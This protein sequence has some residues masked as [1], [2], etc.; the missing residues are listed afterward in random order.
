MP[1]SSMPM[2]RSPKMRARPILL[3]L[4]RNS[5][6]AAS[7]P[8]PQRVAQRVRFS[9]SGGRP[10][11]AGHGIE[12]CLVAKVCLAARHHRLHRLFQKAGHLAARNRGH[13]L[14]LPGDRHHRRRQQRAEART[15]DFR[16]RGRALH[17][18]R[19]EIVREIALDPVKLAECLDQRDAEVAVANLAIK[20]GQTLMLGLEHG[21][22][23]GDCV[24]QGLD[25]EVHVT[26][27]R[28]RMPPARSNR[29]PVRHRAAAPSAMRRPFPWRS[30]IGQPGDGRS[31]V[32]HRQFC[33]RHDC[34]E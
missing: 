1:G 25:R 12:H 6:I 13:P 28:R 2:V 24:S 32:P 29:S 16:H 27:S 26:P 34:K 21:E 9:L 33:R 15:R 18:R 22:D 7:R 10:G 17:Q 5:A 19:P 20:A 31:S 8:L 30:H 3:G 4:S 11:R 14:R 23:A